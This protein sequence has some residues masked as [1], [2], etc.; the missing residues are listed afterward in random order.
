MHKLRILV[1]DDE[2]QMHRFL[3]PA[4]NAA[5]YEPIRAETGRQALAEIARRPPDAVVLD[6]GLP[7]IDGQEVLLKARAFYEGPIIILSARDREMEKIEA[8][9]AGADD[10]VEKPF[11]VGELL[12]RLR[13]TM[14]RQLRQAD[15]PP[16][17]VHAGDLTI[18]IPRRLVTRAGEPVHLSPKEYELLVKL[19]GADGKVL[20]HKDLLISLWGPAH[21]EDMQYLR[22]FI[23]QLRQKIEPDPSAPRLILTQPG[24]GYRFMADEAIRPAVP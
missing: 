19:A 7:D 8:L 3:G 22:V 5:G 14:R 17:I 20:T 4:L 2:P 21:V 12:A 10:Y 18:D 6:L 23:G 1:V 9:D 11:R 24:I 15:A 16:P 13:V